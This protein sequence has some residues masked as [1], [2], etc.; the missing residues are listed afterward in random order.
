[1]VILYS[2]LYCVIFLC[3]P[4]Y[5]E[6]LVS[7]TEFGQVSEFVT[8]RVVTL[9]EFMSNSLSFLLPESATGR[10]RGVMKMS[11]RGQRSREL[12]SVLSL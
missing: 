11:S 12:R 8:F 10:T 5:R 9:S 7:S 1:M 6:L 2:H 3:C 4:T